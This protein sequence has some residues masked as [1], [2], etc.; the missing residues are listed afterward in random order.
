MIKVYVGGS[1]SKHKDNNVAA[2]FYAA[3]RLALAGFAPILPPGAF[4]AEGS[5]PGTP[6]LYRKVIPGDIAGVA[7]C[8]VIIG[9]HGWMHSRG[10]MFERHGADLFD[11]PVIHGP[12][13]EEDPLRYMDDVI[14]LL[15]EWRAA[16]EQRTGV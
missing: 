13:D 2:F 5:Q 6:E 16:N 12:D 14:M 10:Y 7:Q 9:L 8:D 1:M 3:W 4:G 15:H 11:M